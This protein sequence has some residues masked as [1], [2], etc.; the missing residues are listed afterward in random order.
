MICAQKKAPARKRATSVDPD[1]SELKKLKVIYTNSAV[2]KRFL[3]W[4]RKLIRLSI[5]T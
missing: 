5:R 3:T 4:T 2:V 1:Q